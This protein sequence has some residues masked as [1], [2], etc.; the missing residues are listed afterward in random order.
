MRVPGEQ[1][2]W[3]EYRPM[4]PTWQRPSIRSIAVE[5]AAVLAEALPGARHAVV[6]GAGHLAP[7]ETPDAFRE[8]VLVLLREQS[9][10]S[11]TPGPASGAH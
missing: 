5:G 3:A 8:L 2:P 10:P 6:E 7:L 9:K 11:A 1:A 4:P